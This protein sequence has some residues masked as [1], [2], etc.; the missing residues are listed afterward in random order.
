V[1]KDSRQENSTF[2]SRRELPACYTASGE[3]FST[4]GQVF[5]AIAAPRVLTLDSTDPAKT[6]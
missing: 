6:N 1:R 2:G 4:A 5:S 3:S